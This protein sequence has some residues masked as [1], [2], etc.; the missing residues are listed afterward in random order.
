MEGWIDF[1]RLNDWSFHL[2]D[3]LA[4]YVCGGG[5]VRVCVCVHVCV[6]VR[7]CVRACV[8][9]CA[10]TCARTQWW[11]PKE[12]LRNTHLCSRRPRMTF[13]SFMAK[14]WPMQFLKTE[15]QTAGMNQPG[16]TGLLYTG[17]IYN[18]NSRQV[19]RGCFILGVF[20]TQ[21]A[22][23]WD[24][25]ALYWEY[26]WHKQWKRLGHISSSCTGHSWMLQIFQ[27]GN[28]ISSNNQ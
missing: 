20:T 6:C 22:G 7:A 21:T 18:T 9:V 12:K 23:R 28:F 1:F 16:G 27:K 3:S 19:G 17:S 2:V 15:W 10:H 13:S 25:G 11:N 24:R 26:L 8:R 14:C 4:W 5:G